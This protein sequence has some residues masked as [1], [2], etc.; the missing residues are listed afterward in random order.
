MTQYYVGIDLHK[1]MA[2]VCV[3]DGQGQIL[4]GRRIRLD[5][6]D[7]GSALLDFLC[8]WRDGGRYVV[9]A[10]GMNRW[11]VNACREAVLDVIVADP[12]KLGLKT[13]GKK[14]DKRDAREMARRLRLGDIDRFAATYYPSDREYGVR[15]LV[16]VRH[17]LVQV[18]QELV[19]QI[20]GLLNAYLVRPPVQRLWWA[21]GLAW[22]RTCE[23]PTETM[24]ACVRALGAAMESVQAQIADLSARIT[25]VGQEK[26]VRPLVEHLPN[27]AAQTAT[28]IL[29]EL[30]DVKR[31]RNARAAS[32][33]AGLV[34]RVAQ[35]A[36]TSHH[37]RL[38]KR[39]SRELRW[40]LSQW[41]VRLFGD[42]PTGEGLG[43]ATPAARAQKQG[44]HRA[45]A[46]PARRRLRHAH[47]RGDLLP[48]AVPR[49]V[50]A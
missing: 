3:T 24:T 44:P 42:R 32:S 46:P 50:I 20:R 23:L 15:K 49:G 39:G 40:A 14:T 18:R 17:G 16:R 29:Y 5:D 21:K 45:R 30:G 11:L 2:Q 12:V 19:N 9:E 27:V 43:E 10:V 8:E 36:D 7:R 38:T 4:A 26:E 13:L 35:S 6:G 28:T 1:T 37:G 22:L 48:R 41:A 31:F 47:P 25:A 34:P 33:Y